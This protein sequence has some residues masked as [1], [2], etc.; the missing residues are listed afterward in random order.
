MLM[1]RDR[2]ERK[3]VVAPIELCAGGVG[4]LLL[5]AHKD[6]VMRMRTAMPQV[7]KPLCVLL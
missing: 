1:M 5:F 6:D 4:Q 7:R 2:H 3:A